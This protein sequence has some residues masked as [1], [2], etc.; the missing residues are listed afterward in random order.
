MQT[1]ILQRLNGFFI[2]FLLVNLLH[3]QPDSLRK[4]SEGK[5]LIQLNTYLE[6]SKVPRNRPVVFHIELSWEGDLS[7]YQIEPVSQPILTNLLLEGSGSENRLEPLQNGKFRAVKSITYRFKPLE[8]GMAYIDGV[9][10]KYTDR[11]TGQED[12]L[13][14]QRVMV[15]IVDPLPEADGGSVRSVIYLIL[16]VVFFAVIL[17]FVIIYF[18]KRRQ[19]RESVVPIVPLPEIYLNKLS[20]EVD[21]R[22][23]NL[24]EMTGRLSKI[25]RE[26]LDQDFDIRTRES[27]TAEILEKL[28]NL[29]IDEN[30][31]SNLRSVFEKLDLIKF[32]GK[33]VDPAD[34]TNIYGTIEA[35]LLKRKQVYESNQAE[36]KE[37]K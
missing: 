31:R 1:K 15:E 25:F 4:P 34:F 27:S 17:F 36:L 28:E 33:N 23:T 22:G 16:L 11:Q 14:S 9:T 32:A 8:M 2:L 37:D 10:I 35:F 30:D 26:Y 7:R 3:S 21:P 19:A 29:D 20:Q 12:K 5:Q 13:T 6:T 18:K 24:N